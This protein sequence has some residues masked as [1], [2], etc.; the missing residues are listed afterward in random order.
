[1]DEHKAL[2]LKWGRGN[3]SLVAQNGGF[4]EI[5][6]YYI[7]AY[8]ANTVG[9]FGMTDEV[10]A[11]TNA[12]NC[13]FGAANKNAIFVGFNKTLTTLRIYAANATSVEP[14]QVY[15]CGNNYNISVATNVYRQTMFAKTNGG[16]VS[17]FIQRVDDSTIAPCQYTFAGNEAMLPLSTVP[18]GWRM[19]MGR[20][21]SAVGTSGVI[22]GMNK[23]Y[24]SSDN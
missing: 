24:I 14:L 12:T 13:F 5:L 18:L 4:K 19:F 16:N 7:G 3:S 10:T 2:G 17:L 20:S 9:C 23:V 21:Q 6:T 22:F 11:Y 1:L 15:D 8:D